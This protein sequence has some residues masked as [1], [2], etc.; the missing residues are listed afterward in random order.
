MIR[1]R[2]MEVCQGCC[3]R[4]LSKLVSGGGRGG[5]EMFQAGGRCL[6]F[7]V[8]CV[9]VFCLFGWFGFFVLFVVVVCLGFVFVWFLFCLF[10]CF[11]LFCCFCSV[12]SS[13]LPDYRLRA[14]LKSCTPH[15][16]PTPA[17]TMKTLAAADSCRGRNHQIGH[18]LGDH[19]AGVC[20]PWS[21]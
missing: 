15:E 5:G 13:G 3:R 18:H 21:P 8:D 12:S 6:L 4:W 14:H 17:P 1:R 11:V 2:V 16:A 7:E 20:G 10:V 9:A 19:K